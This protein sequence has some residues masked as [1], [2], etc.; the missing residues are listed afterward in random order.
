MPAGQ[1]GEA[2]NTR[3]GSNRLP[4]PP[5]PTRCSTNMVLVWRR[6]MRFK[7]R[8]SKHRWRSC[9]TTRGRCA[10]QYASLSRH[11][12]IGSGPFGGSEAAPFSCAGEEGTCSLARGSFRSTATSGGGSES[13]HACGFESPFLAPPASVVPP[14]ALAWSARDVCQAVR[15]TGQQ[16]HPYAPH[17]SCSSAAS[18]AAASASASASMRSSS[19]WESSGA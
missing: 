19:A 18:C 1:R 9:N 11:M 16:C 15:S 17:L 3:S 10:R 8:A 2:V 6:C 7:D 4:V 13:L 12:H 5:A 14:L